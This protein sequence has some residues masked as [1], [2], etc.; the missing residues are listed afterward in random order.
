MNIATLLELPSLLA[1]DYPAVVEGGRSLSYAELAS[2]AAATAEFLTASGIGRGDVVG[3]LGANHL[4]F[5]SAAMGSAAT[6]ACLAA[7]NHRAGPEDLRHLVIDSAVRL[8]VVD[9]AAAPAAAEVAAMLG[10]P[11]VTLDRLAEIEAAAPPRGLEVTVETDEADPAILIYTSGTTARAKGV[12]LSHGALTEYVLSRT[13]AADGTDVGRTLLSVP[14]FHVAGISTLLASLYG[15]RTVVLEPRFEPAEWLALVARNRVTHAFLVPT[16]LAKLLDSA[17]FPAA[18]LSSLRSISYGAAPMPPT[19]L[20]RIV[21]AFPSEVGF[22]GAYGLSESTSTVA[23]LD[24]DDHRRFMAARTPQDAALVRSAGRPVP[25]VRIEILDADD[26]PLGPDRAG[27]I[28]IVSRRNVQTYWIAGQRP[29]AAPA[30]TRLV[31]GDLGHL[32]ERGYLFI[33]GR[34]SDLLIRGGENIS[35]LEVENAI[36]GDPRVT[37]C[38]VVGLPDES[39]GEIVAAFV[40]LRDPG[41]DFGL[42][43]AIAACAGLTRYKWPERLAVVEELPRTATGKLLRRALTA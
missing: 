6:G 31:T 20:H 27:R 22:S 13:D 28:A 7:L 23:V 17:A 24:E 33:T 21:A 5:V 12:A 11:V 26:T 42:A 3:Y 18:D 30:E 9:T 41:T 43:D 19:L 25:D 38:A 37:D 32:D 14:L 15:G 39:W 16:M 4:P 40:V 29:P 36:L 8:L 34:Q 10:V 35:P 2:R 1:G